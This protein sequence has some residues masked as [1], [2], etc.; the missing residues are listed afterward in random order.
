MGQTGA[1][2]GEP[3]THDQRTGDINSQIFYDSSFLLL[4]TVIQIL[5][6]SSN[7][8]FFCH[9]T[10]ITL[11][12]CPWLCSCAASFLFFCLGGGDAK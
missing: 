4:L 7:C 10:P 1:C 2:H 11:L 5:F 3:P 6:S 12:L 8:L 9:F